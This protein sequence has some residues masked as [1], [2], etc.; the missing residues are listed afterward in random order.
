MRYYFTCNHKKSSSIYITIEMAKRI[1]NPS[2]LDVSFEEP[3]TKK[4]AQSVDES[5]EVKQ[6]VDVQDNI[7]EILKEMAEVNKRLCPVLEKKRIAL[8]KALEDYNAEL[9]E[10][11]KNKEG[12]IKSLHEELLECDDRL[13]GMRTDCASR[14]HLVQ[15]INSSDDNKHCI[16]NDAAGLKVRYVNNETF[17]P[18]SDN[19][20][21]Y[22]SSRKIEQISHPIDICNTS[23]NG[24]CIDPALVW[25]SKRLYILDED[26]TNGAVRRAIQSG[27]PDPVVVDKDNNVVHDFDEIK[28]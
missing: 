6:V 18:D 19:E 20:K 7:K 12:R 24:R 13:K 8:M 15:G 16:C 14:K 22:R 21:A 27:L 28:K 3:P 23:P 9:D 5:D 25:E 4:L 11:I 26:T 10:E 17:F 1:M 2:N